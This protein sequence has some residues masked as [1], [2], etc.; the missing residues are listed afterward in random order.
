MPPA[1]VH[2]ESSLQVLMRQEDVPLGDPVCPSRLGPY[3]LPVMWQLYP[4]RRYRGSDSSFWRIVYHIE[5]GDTE[6]M[7][8]E[9]MPDPEYA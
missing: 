1:Q 3:L 7:L 9:Q 6:D 8:L 4:G 5:F 2:I